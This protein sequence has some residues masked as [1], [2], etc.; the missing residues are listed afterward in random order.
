[1]LYAAFV[2]VPLLGLLGVLRAGRGLEAPQSVGGSW[3]LDSGGRLAGAIACGQAEDEDPI[4]LRIGQ[5]G[6]HIRLELHDTKN[7]LFTGKLDGK[8]VTAETPSSGK[9]SSP[10]R[11]H[12]DVD[13]ANHPPTLAGTLDVDRCNK[14]VP[15]RAVREKTNGSD[16]LS[17]AARRPSASDRGDPGG[18]PDRRLGL[19]K[20]RPAAGRR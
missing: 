16:V 1:M 4:T 10:M 7:Y 13:P 8:S 17:R 11:I 6:P 14:Q 5:S 19:S 9:D 3:K 12:A 20:A 2:G 15:F 18:D